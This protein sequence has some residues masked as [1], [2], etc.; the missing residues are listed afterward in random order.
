MP[1][2]L[3]SKFWATLYGSSSIYDFKNIKNYIGF[4]IEKYQLSE[5]F[6]TDSPVS[7]SSFDNS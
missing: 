1:E 2:E 3:E 4:S 5:E 6:L 7:V